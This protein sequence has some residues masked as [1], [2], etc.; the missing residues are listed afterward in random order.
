MRKKGKNLFLIILDILI[1]CTSLL[2]AWMIRSRFRAFLYTLEGLVFILPY[3]V[4]IRII[5]STIFE[6]YSYRYNKYYIE[7]I[8]SLFFHNLFPSFVFL[9]LRFFSPVQVTRMPLAM[10]FV[11]FFLTTS[12]MILARLLL[13]G[14]NKGES[15]KPVCRRKTVIVAFKTE[16]GVRKNIESFMDNYAFDVEGIFT[17]D[18]SVWNTDI[19]GIKIIGAPLML[20]KILD[21]MHEINTIIL[22]GKI[23]REPALFILKLMKNK[24][25][26]CYCLDTGGKLVVPDENY[27]AGDFPPGINY[28][29]DKVSDFLDRKKILIHSKEMFF[30]VSSSSGIIR[31]EDSCLSFF[32]LIKS[33]EAE[34]DFIVDF[35]ENINIADAKKNIYE[36]PFLFLDKIMLDM[37]QFKKIEGFIFKAYYLFLQG[38]G[39]KFMAL[40]MDKVVEDIYS[41]YKSC[42]FAEKY[43]IDSQPAIAEKITKKAE[44]VKTE[45]TDL[46]IME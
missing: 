11:E 3:V 6:E 42:E 22:T 15:K 32:A 12:G 7:N 17:E 26:E 5:S 16:P 24:K 39:R 37:K 2:A 18:S 28:L 30:G 40:S 23:P 4:L 8:K 33:E 14:A 41:G 46:Y 34:N 45:F 29:P 43:R 20:E 36:E 13:A 21:E 35:V 19:G 38:K 31:E 44:W 1:I 9:L 25:I 27:F 10:I